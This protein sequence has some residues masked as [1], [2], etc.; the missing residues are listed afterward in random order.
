VME[1]ELGV[2]GD[3]IVG[4]MVLPPLCMG[5]A[6]RRGE[7]LGRVVVMIAFSVANWW[8][9]ALGRAARVES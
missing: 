2:G 9:V 8:S 1:V 5:P 4:P 6:A 3:G 7:P